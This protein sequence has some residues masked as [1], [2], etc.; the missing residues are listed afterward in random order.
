MN[1][2][3]VKEQLLYEIGDPAHYL[4]PDATVT[5]LTL[6]VEDEGN[7]RVRVSGATGGP[8]PAEYK[9][10]ATFRSGYRASGMLLVF[11]RDAVAKARRC[12]EIVLEK[13]ANPDSRR[14]SL[15]SNAW[16]AAR[17]CPAFCRQRQM[18]RWKRYCASA[19]SIRNVKLSSGSR[20]S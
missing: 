14:P 6:R 12:G 10:S 3:T 9:V 5:F 18:S 19:F 2:Q 16:E 4:S 17:P 11:G 7:D 15:S 8:P 1:K 13:F 20:G